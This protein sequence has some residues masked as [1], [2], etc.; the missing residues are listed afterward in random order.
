[1][2]VCR[3]LSMERRWETVQW[4]CNIQLQRSAEK[5]DARNSDTTP[6]WPMREMLRLGR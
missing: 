2:P 3:Q 1:V 4:S 5:A 6:R